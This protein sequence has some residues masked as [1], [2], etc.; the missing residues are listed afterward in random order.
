MKPFESFLAPK[1][2]QYLTYR[3]A[4]GYT[5]NRLRGLL[6]TFDQYVK[7]KDPDWNAF[8][9]LFFLQFSRDLT[10]QPKTVN[11]IVSAVRWFFQ[12]LVRQGHLLQNPVAHVPAQAEK[13]FIPFIFSPQQTEHLLGAI[14]NSIRKTKAHFLQDLTVYLAILLLARCGMRISEPLQLLRT[15]YRPAEQTLYIEKTKFKKDRLIP[16][17]NSAIAEIQNYLAVRNTLCTCDQNPYLL[18]GQ[19]QS[20]LKK[21]QVYQVFRQALKDI[22]IYHPRRT[23]ANVTFGSPTPH[24]LRHSFAVNTLKQIKDKGKSP[25]AALPI[26]AA[27]MGHRKYRYTA[28]YLKVLDANQRQQLVDFNISRQK[29]L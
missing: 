20:P 14:Q 15:H 9:P 24:S 18:A 26:L 25:Q 27:Y 11:E 12:F 22:G 23:I 8:T 29:D 6:R 5:E 17:P 16:V 2:E 28:V 7:T 1:L 19:N 21:R 10:K 4:I 3:T 13:S